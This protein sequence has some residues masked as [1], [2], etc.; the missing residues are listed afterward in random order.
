MQWRNSQKRDLQGEDTRNGLSDKN[1]TNEGKVI[2]FQLE[3]G[4]Q[5][6]D[7]STECS[8]RHQGK[9]EEVN[10]CCYL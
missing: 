8:S 10:K 1:I 9:S 2:R 3:L 5:L 7:V 6:A 4:K